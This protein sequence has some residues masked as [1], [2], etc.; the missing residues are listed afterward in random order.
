MLSPLMRVLAPQSQH[1][2]TLEAEL[3]AAWDA[4]SVPER[5]LWLRRVLEHI[6]V[7]PAAAQHRGSDVESRFAPVWKV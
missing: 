5:R 7:R 3:R 1:T 6:T 4:W 2:V